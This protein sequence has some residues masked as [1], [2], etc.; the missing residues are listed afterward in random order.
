MPGTPV[1]FAPS[2]A[3]RNWPVTWRQPRYRDYRTLHFFKHESLHWIATIIS[4]I[5]I[6]IIIIAHI[7][8]LLST[9]LCD[10]ERL[11][12]TGTAIRANGTIVSG[13]TKKPG[14]VTGLK[15]RSDS[16]YVPQGRKA[17]LLWSGP[18]PVCLPAPIRPQM[19]HGDS[20][21]SEGAFSTTK[22]DVQQSAKRFLHRQQ[23]RRHDHWR[24]SPY[25]D[26]AP[27]IGLE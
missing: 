1:I 21:F 9:F 11:I 2:A 8:F 18:D 17:P 23:L 25:S 6:A 7:L 4:A 19:G 20:V 16:K 22:Q 24:A 5:V 26:A 10:P 15:Q 12:P 14:S 3:K 27:T 13:V